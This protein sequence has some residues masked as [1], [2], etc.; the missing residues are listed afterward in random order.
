[1]QLIYVSSVVSNQ[2]SHPVA[3]GLGGD[4]ALTQLLQGTGLRFEHLTSHSIRIFVGPAP[5]PEKPVRV[6]PGAERDEVI[7]TASRGTQSI[8]DVPTTIQTI[9]G[10][11]LK[12][13]NATTTADLLKYTSNVTFSGDSPGTGNIF[14][15][16]LG[17]S[18]TGAQSQ[19]TIAP[20][21][22]VA[23]Y[24]DD[25]SMQFPG[26]NN[27]VYLADMERVEVLEGPQGT[28][29]GGG[30]QAGVIRYVTNKPQL[31]AVAAEITASYGTTAGGDPTS[32]V[33]ALLNVPLAENR[34]GLR[35]VIF[36][37]HRGGYIDN[38]PATIGYFPGSIPYDFGGNPSA[39]NAS[40]QAANSN[41]VD[42]GGAR[43]SALWRINDR[44]EA[45]LQQNVQDTRADGYFFAYPTSTDGRALQPYQLTAFAPALNRDR[46][47]STALTISGRLGNMLDV[48]YSGS[49]MTRHIEA[50]Q[51]YSNY[52]RSSTASSYYACIGT[53]AGYFNPYLFPQLTGKPLQC[54]P[55]VGTW[56]DQASSQH[57]SHEIRI[58]TDPSHR[59]RGLAGAYWERFGI[60]D[61]M[62]FNYLGIPHCSQSNLDIARAGG[63]DCISAVGPLPGT[64]T[65]TPGL[66]TEANTAFGEDIQRG[67]TQTALFSSIDIDLVPK[68]L[69]VTAGL[70]LYRYDEFE[71]GSEYYTLD[72]TGG[73]VVDNP[74]GACTAVG[75]CGFPIN[76]SKSESGHRWRG[77]LAWHATPDIMAY[78]TYSE[79][80]NPGGFNRAISLP[81]Q[82]PT[83]SG[84]AP[85]SRSDG[86]TRQYGRPAG[87]DS[88]SLINNEIGFKADFLNHRVVLNVSAY[89][90]QWEHI[91]QVLF[92]PVSLGNVSFNVNGAS[93][94]IR[95]IEVQFAAR[96]TEGLSVQG[97]SSVNT[98]TQS[99]TPCLLSVGIDPNVGRTEHNPTPKGHCITQINDVPYTN[100]FGQLGARSPFA[101]P[102]MFNVLARYDWTAADYRPFAWI[103]ASHVGPMSTQ[104]ANFP[105]GNDPSE[106]PPTGAPST[107]LLRYEVPGHT[108]YD[109]GFGVAK[110]NWIAQI[111]CHNL[112][113]E[114]GPRNISSSQF[115]KAEVPLRPRVIALL[116]GYRF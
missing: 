28:L 52:L 113:N 15:R 89:Y 17:G 105:D 110:D 46:Y 43:I 84:E 3:A 80:L 49:Y 59:V 40:L 9:T 86:L 65:T 87:F 21:P 4:E 71:H 82:P 55:P 114:Y 47:E 69:T 37:E 50:Q 63:A 62:N 25:Q 51:D 7:V 11:Q 41:A 67:Y 116:I 92:D 96:L 8:Q 45:L 24:L 115:I 56:H 12:Q 93:Y 101:P 16:G 2:R 30:A 95:G 6:L 99:D 36:S 66:R 35:A 68:V 75:A 27:D 103:G 13:R 91:Q 107:T 60:G 22:N 32:T 48:V 83:L 104:P 64:F 33:Q 72:S 111:Q 57:Q 81:G 109:G 112:T 54:S 61:N 90:M 74:N 58:S 100:P 85:Y 38:V 108:T 34:F 102:W 70:R 44:W 106:S 31:E 53:G 10:E 19:A 97:S 23:L 79:G 94:I 42:I 29:F 14:M 76:L 39:N 73:L 88:D 18:G 77:S 5:P 20:F 78:Y 26:H 98:P 1:M